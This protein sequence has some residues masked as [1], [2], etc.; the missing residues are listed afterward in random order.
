LGK[1]ISSKGLDKYY[2]QYLDIGIK[3][4]INLKLKNCYDFYYS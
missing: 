3:K 4:A 1:G 2:I